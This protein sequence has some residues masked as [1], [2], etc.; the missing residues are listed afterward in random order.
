VG[1][2]H[3]RLPTNPGKSPLGAAFDGCYFRCYGGG[4]G[5]PAHQPGAHSRGPLCADPSD[6]AQRAELA[7]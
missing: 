4:I 3:E 7:L 5:P 6:R 1:G 2:A